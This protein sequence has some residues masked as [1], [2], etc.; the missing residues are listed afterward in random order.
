MRLQF[1]IVLIFLSLAFSALGQDSIAEQ[2]EKVPQE[3]IYDID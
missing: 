1:K 3:L 2:E